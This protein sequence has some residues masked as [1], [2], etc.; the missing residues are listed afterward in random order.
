MS[1]LLFRHTINYREK[2]EHANYLTS[3]QSLFKLIFDVLREREF[4]MAYAHV[5][6]RLGYARFT[7][8]IKATNRSVAALERRFNTA[9]KNQNNLSVISAISELRVNTRSADMVTK[10]NLYTAFS[11]RLVETHRLRDLRL[12]VDAW[13]NIDAV[14]TLF[15]LVDSLSIERVTV[16]NFLAHCDLTVE[17]ELFLNKARGREVK[18][19]SYLNSIYPNV[20]RFLANEE[21]LYTYPMSRIRNF[22]NVA[23]YVQKEHCANTSE[24]NRTNEM[25]EWNLLQ[26]KNRG[27]RKSE[28]RFSVNNFFRY[29]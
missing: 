17:E 22:L 19:V 1:H 25:N 18:L 3:V 8:H 20:R 12:S 13:G 26:V 23:L 9:F 16:G 29:R 27:G 24:L 15:Y 11:Q 21:S 28:V 5:N 10:L 7:E 14:I 6:D 2:L 4:A